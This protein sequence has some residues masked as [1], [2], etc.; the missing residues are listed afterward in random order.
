MTKTNIFSAQECM[1]MAQVRAGVDATDAALIQLLATR[2]A[3]MQA[4]ARIKEN[5]DAVRDEARKAQVIGNA[6]AMA[7][8]AGLP[9]QDIAALWEL[10]VESSI[11]YEAR[12]WDAIR[13]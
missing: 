13:V 3:Y 10:L 9:E 11:V 4:A 12:H 8:K 6:A 5:R 7:Q 2:Y 1:T